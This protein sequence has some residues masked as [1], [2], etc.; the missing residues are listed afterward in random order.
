MSKRLSFSAWPAGAS[1]ALAWLLAAAPALAQAPTPAAGERSIAPSTAGAATIAPTPPASAPAVRAPD[2]TEVW[3]ALQKAGI[4]DSEVALLAQPLAAGAPLLISHNEKLAFTLASTTKVITTLASLQTLPR[5]YRW[6]TRAWLTGA[7]VDGRLAGDLILVGGGDA[8]LNSQRL[9]DWFRRLHKQG[10]TQVQ[11][12]IVLDQSLFRL[13]DKDHANTPVPEA[14]N[15]HHAWPD[16]FVL[17]ESRFRV[18]LRAG[19]GGALAATFDPPLGRSRSSTSSAAGGPARR[20]RGSSRHR[21][22]IF[23]SRQPSPLR[24]QRPRHR[25]TSRSRPP[26]RPVPRPAPAPHQCRRPLPACPSRPPHHPPP[27]PRSAASS[28]AASGRRAAPAR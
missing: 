27:W 18:A 28:S 4:K 21:H 25:P 6:R 12:H 19:D 10:L 13:A 11:G 7:P 2:A 26:A 17:D 9:T 23:R 22:L 3:T 8:T 16:A 20:R 15:P 5:N 24:R 14:G 1:A